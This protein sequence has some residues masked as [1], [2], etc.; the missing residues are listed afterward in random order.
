MWI[1]LLIVSKSKL[2]SGMSV[3]EM[4]TLTLWT[5]EKL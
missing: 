4:E 2:S 5:F 1:S 3:K